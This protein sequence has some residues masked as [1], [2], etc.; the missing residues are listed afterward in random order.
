MGTLPGVRLYR[1]YG[2]EGAEPVDHTLA[3]GL[4]IRFV[5]M[6]KSANS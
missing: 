6:H 4:T 2:Y 3:P 1:A 5:P